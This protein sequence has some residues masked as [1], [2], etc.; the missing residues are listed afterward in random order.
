M[1]ALSLKLPLLHLFRSLHE[2]RCPEFFW[3]FSLHFI[4]VIFTPTTI[5]RYARYIVLDSEMQALSLKLPLLHLFRSLHEKRCPEFFWTFSLHFITVIYTPT[6]IHRYSRYIVLDSEMQA[7]S[8]KLPLLHLFRSLHEKRC[9]EFFWT[10]SL[11]FVTVIYTPTTI[12]RYS[13]YIV[14]DTEMQALSLK[15]PLLHLFRSLHEKRCPEFFWTFSLHFIT[16]IYT[17]TTIH[18]YSGY[19]V[20]DTE[21]Q[22]LS[23]K[24]PL[25]HLFRSLHEKRCP[26]FFWTFSLHFVTVIYT[27]TTIH[28]YSRYIVLDSE[29]QALSLKLPLLHLFRSLHEKRCP[30]FFWTFSLHFITVI[31]TPTT[32]HRYSGYMVLDT[33]MQALSLK[34]PLLHLFRS[35][36]EKRC[37]E[38]FWTF[39]LHF[40]TVIYTSTTIHR[41]S[42]YIVL[43]S[44]MQALSLKLPLLH[45]FRS[46]HEKR[47][48]EFFWT[49][50]LHFITVIYTPTTIHRYSRYI[51]LDTE[52]QALSLKLPL[53]HLFRSLHEKRCPEFF[54]TFSL[55]F[56]TVI[57]TPTTIHR[58]SRYIVLDSEMQAL[59]LKL[60]LLHLF[61]SLHEKRC[62]EFFWTFSL[63]FVTVIYTP[64]TIHRYSRYIVLDTE[65]QALSLKLPLLHLF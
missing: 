38:F 17:P 39:S 12:H 59:S 25:L 40:V 30:E 6:T 47:C 10:F 18:R 61:R 32:I 20:L 5:H 14:L 57:Y 21:M 16:V 42:R 29:M 43:D 46:L 19:M 41:Y 37:P 58:Y 34:L 26:E 60:P 22:A 53:L 24:L 28:R 23:L 4:T 52:M 50:S 44:E 35:L 45:L 8:L 51:V 3:T 48:P 7:L 56:I 49:F 36:H 33:E 9:P 13:R 63:H 65:M 62:P 31:Y 54:W 1:Q 64:S 11:H 55:H 15:L 2:K 27:S